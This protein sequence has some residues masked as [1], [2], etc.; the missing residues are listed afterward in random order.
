[1]GKIYTIRIDLIC[2]VL[3]TTALDGSEDDDILCFREGRTRS[4]GHE[5]LSRQQQLIDTPEVNNFVPDDDDIV[6]ACPEEMII[7]D[8]EQG[9]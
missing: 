5:M 3:C 8:D 6:A 7:S 1:M 2:K 4:A 9:E